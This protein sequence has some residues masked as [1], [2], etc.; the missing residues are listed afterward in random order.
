MSIVINTNV[1]ALTAQSSLNKAQAGLTQSLERMTTGFKINRAADDAAGLSIATNLNTQ[2]RGSQVAQD[3]IQQGVNVLQTTEGAL[4]TI[5]D[6]INRIRDLA[7]QAA[8]GVNSTASRLAIQS[9]VTARVAEIN[10]TADATEFNGVKLLNG[11]I[12]S[13][14]LQVGANS[15]TTENSITVSDVFG[16]AKCSTLGLTTP[17]ATAF[18]DPAAAASFIDECD[19]AL[20]NLTEKR[21]NIGAYQNRLG[22]TLDNL[23]VTVENMTAS[24][25]TIMDADIAKES[26]T[27]TKQNILQQASASLLA[28]A[29]QTPSIALTLI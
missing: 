2:I 15:N 5:S 10:K 11:S 9:E 21:S 1:L 6:N 18:A 24:K 20:E 12:T 7:A 13:M 26:S 3:N 28:Q 8:N 16:N 19:T 27:Y 4:T 17:V 22:S 29:N 25:S 23:K 14:R